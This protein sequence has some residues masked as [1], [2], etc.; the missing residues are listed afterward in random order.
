MPRRSR[1]RA[2]RRGPRAQ[3][4][5]LGALARW[6]RGGR[7]VRRRA[8]GRAR[9]LGECSSSGPTAAARASP[10]RSAP[11]APTGSRATAVAWS[12]ATSTIPRREPARRRPISSGAR[13]T[14]FAFAFPTAPEGRLLILFM[15]HRD[16][17][18]DARSDPEGYWQRKL[19]EHPGLAERIAGARQEHL[20]EIALDGRDARVL[21]RVVRAGLGAGGRRGAFQGPGHRAGHARR[22]VDGPY[23][24]RARTAGARRPG[25][26]RRGDARLGGR[27]R[28]RLPARLPLRQPRHARGAPVP[29]ALRACARRRSNHGARPHRPLRPRAHVR[30]DRAAAAPDPRARRRALARRAT[31]QGDAEI[32][33]PRRPHRPR[34]APRA[35]C[36]PLPGRPHR[37]R[38]GPP[39]CRV[40][41]AAATAP[42]SDP[43][44]TQLRP[45][46]RRSRH[47][48]HRRRP[49]RAR[50]RGGRGQPDPHR[51][52]HPRRPPGAQR[53]R[54]PRPRG[55]HVAE[56]VREGPARHRAPDRRPALPAA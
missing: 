3:H 41:G 35:R 13:E 32:R 23:A 56:R 42:A 17:V 50:P 9:H 20:H 4:I 29:G 36:R 2:G 8:G 34:D 44:P 26:T 5:L 10:R 33:R 6:A 7:A 45:L 54:G 18:R 55:L 37:D 49:A 24:R 51:G 43:L 12:S 11:G 22:A 27:A 46:T 52:P 53:R 16:E 28:P 21:P 25:R 19:D 1:P 31:A 30:R 38:L 15:G 14:R 39:G 40:A 48:P 47:D